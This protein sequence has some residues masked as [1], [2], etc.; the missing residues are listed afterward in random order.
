MNSS[1]ILKANWPAPKN[2]HAFTTLRHGMGFSLAPFDEFNMGNRNS[3]QGDD[4]AAVEKNRDLL[5]KEFSLPDKPHW[6]RQVHGIDVLRF[7]NAPAHSA[8]FLQDEPVADASVTSRK[9]VVLSVLTADCLPVLFCNETG[10]GTEIAAAHA[11]WRGLADGMLENTVH[12]M[13][14]KP[15]NII[16]WLGPAAGPASYEIGV[17]VRDAFVNHDKNA[18]AAFVPTREN[19]WRVDLYWLA[20][21]RLQAVGVTKIHGGN[22]CTISEPEN[23]FSHRRDKVTG[24]MASVIWMAG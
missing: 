4:P 24:R 18:A 16:A 11:G 17:E 8:N 3:E 20:R 1:S 21:M 10:T 2:I 7:E 12:A 15:E 5:L 6:L 14:S 22:H 23:F 9:N 13:N 19:H